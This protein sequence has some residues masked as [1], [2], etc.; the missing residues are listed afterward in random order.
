MPHLPDCDFTVSPQAG[1]L[2]FAAC[3]FFWVQARRAFVREQNG[4]GWLPHPATQADADVT[5]TRISSAEVM[6]VR[7]TRSILRRG[8]CRKVNGLR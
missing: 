1:F 6:E 5:T 3:A 8:D 2:V 7:C 4:V